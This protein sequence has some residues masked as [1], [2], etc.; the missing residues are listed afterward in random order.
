MNMQALALAFLAATAIG[1]VA[2]VFLYPLL[3]GERKAENRR[4]SVAG[5]EPVARNVDKNQRSRR[6]QVE[7]SMKEL[8]ARRQKDKKVSLSSRLTQ[9]GLDW[10]P[11]KFMMISAILGLVAFAAVMLPALKP[12]DSSGTAPVLVDPASTTSSVDLGLGKSLV[13]DL[14]RNVTSVRTSDP[15][16]ANASMR[17]AQ[18]IYV[19][20][21][22]EGR[23]SIVVSDVA[24]KPVATY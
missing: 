22:T 10:T 2:W 20:A 21:A 9:A 7:G 6:E 5:P 1:G 15:T 3:S 8:D 18:Q 14:R 13:I 23:T 16:I 12:A 4:A 17:S 11:K 19:T 24:G